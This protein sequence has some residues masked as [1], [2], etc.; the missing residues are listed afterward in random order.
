MDSG[1]TVPVWV[2][3]R[4]GYGYR[5]GTSTGR[6]KGRCSRNVPVTYLALARTVVFLLT[7]FARQHYSTDLHKDARSQLKLVGMLPKQTVAVYFADL[8]SCI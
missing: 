2:R 6:I 1:L 4:A 3:V 8:P 7:L 5:S